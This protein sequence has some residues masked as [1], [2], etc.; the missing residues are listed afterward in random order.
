MKL[1]AFLFDFDGVL[2]RS[3]DLHHKVYNRV[4]K[5]MG[6]TLSIEDYQARYIHHDDPGLFRTLNRDRQFGWSEAKVLELSEQARKWFLDEMGNKDIL[7]PGM[8][9]L[10]IKLS[11]RMPLGIVSMGDRRMIEKALQ[12]ANLTVLF[13]AI[14]C[15]DDVKFPK[16]HPEPYRRGLEILNEAGAKI[17][18]E[19]A[20][21][22]NCA[23][24]EDSV[25]GVLSGKAAGMTVFALKHNQSAKLLMEA[26]A[27]HV[28][29]SIAALTSFLGLDD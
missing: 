21:P 27:D 2:G 25:G 22:E 3:E 15:A 24:L 11:A 29:D 10:V 26:R 7:Y 18:L 19:P 17:G 28:L 13:Q 23:V 9:E 5:T 12:N 20:R 8:R 1:Q 4:L 14:V 6:Y 16:P